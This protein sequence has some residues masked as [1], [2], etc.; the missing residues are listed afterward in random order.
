M[1]ELERSIKQALAQDDARLL[2]SLGEDPSLY[3]QVLET[4][5]GRLR[6]LNLLGWVAGF[7]FFVIAC[8][9]AWRFV[10]ALEL[11]SMLL[12]GG[13]ALVAVMAL[14]LVKIWFWMELQKN[15]ILREVKRLEL[16]T[17]RLA[18]RLPVE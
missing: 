6:W 5:Q 10:S 8:I 9:C 3:R 15:A 12:W 11:R 18:A 2:E 16:Q 1:S 7:A 4:F 13:G 14:V 17:A